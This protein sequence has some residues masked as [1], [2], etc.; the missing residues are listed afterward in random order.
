MSGH[1][2]RFER[3]QLGEFQLFDK[4]GVNVVA[5]HAA[6]RSRDGAE[7]LGYPPALGRDRVW[8]AGNLH[9]GSTVGAGGSWSSAGRPPLLIKDPEKIVDLTGRIDAEGRLQWDAPAGRW[10]IVRY[11]CTNTGERLKVPSPN[12]DGLA[13]DHFSREATRTFLNYLIG[14][15]QSKLGN[16]EDT[17][18]KQ[19][20]LASYEVRGAIWTPDM[21]Q[22]FRRYRGY[23]M[24]P[25]LPVLSGSIVLSDDVTRR[26]IYDYRKTLGDLLVDAYYRAAVDTAHAAGLGIES[27]AGGPGPPIHQ[28]PVDA[29]KALGAGRGAWRVLAQAA[30]GRSALGRQGDGLCGPHLRQA[31]RPHGG[32][33][34][35]VSLAGWSL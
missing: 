4:Q 19:L 35:H 14:R 34:E 27:E 25:Y 10:A 33:H 1:N 2:V 17:A 23:D 31:P 16:L 5:S 13:T 9:D 26:F 15:L 12:S 32:V 22:Q 11:V 21:I 7:L 20:Y 29:L 24:T 30:Q 8:T 28:V 3:V 6:D 18:L